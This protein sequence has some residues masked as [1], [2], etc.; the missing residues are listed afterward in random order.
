[1]V[2]LRSPTEMVRVDENDLR[3]MLCGGGGSRQTGNPAA[4]HDYVGIFWHRVLLGWLKELTC[5]VDR[6]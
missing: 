3:S 4:H 5:G 1:M 2:A 6:L